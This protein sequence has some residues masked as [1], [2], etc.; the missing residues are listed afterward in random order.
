MFDV[1]VEVKNIEEK[2]LFLQILSKLIEF[3]NVTFDF[4]KL[5]ILK[6]LR[7]SLYDKQKN[8]VQFSSFLKVCMFLKEFP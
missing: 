3:E 5:K 7:N 8:Q 2:K 4:S 6:E 1:I